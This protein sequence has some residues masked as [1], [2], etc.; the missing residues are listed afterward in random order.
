MQLDTTMSLS[1]L[2]GQKRFRRFSQKWQK[3]GK[4]LVV[5]DVRGL[6]GFIFTDLGPRFLV[7][8]VTGERPIE[9]EVGSIG[10][11]GVVTVLDI[12]G[13]HGLEEG[14]LVT[15][16]G[17]QGMEEINGETRKVIKSLSP[18]A[19]GIGDTSYFS[20]EGR[21]GNAVQERTQQ[22]MGHRPLS[23]AI[24]KP[25]FVESDWA[26]LDRPQQLHL[27]FRGCTSI[28]TQLFFC[29]GGAFFCA[30]LNLLEIYVDG[31]CALIRFHAF[32][33]FC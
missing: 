15:F 30:F 24:L 31:S 5:A 18:F 20:E 7:E 12:E 13:R 26:K 17:I 4:A 23:E 22:V 1:S 28:H 16:K 11:D 14:D 2:V 29:P 25:K 3:C 19:F 10:L 32:P 27:A 21:G 8:D 9:I 6:A 33:I